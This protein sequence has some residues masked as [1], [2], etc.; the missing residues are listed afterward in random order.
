MGAPPIG[1][2]SCPSTGGASSSGLASGEGLIEHLADMP[3]E[4]GKHVPHQGAVGQDS[5]ADTF[6]HGDHHHG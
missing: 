4:S 6:G 3:S 5:G 1:P 2:G